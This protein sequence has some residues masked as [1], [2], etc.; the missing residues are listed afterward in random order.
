MDFN[1]HELLN[2]WIDAHRLLK[3]PDGIIIF[4]PSKGRW[5]KCEEYELIFKINN[6]NVDVFFKKVVF[7]YLGRASTTHRKAFEVMVRECGYSVNNIPQL[8]VVSNFLKSISNFCNFYN[9]S[10]FLS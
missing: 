5:C 6:K 7:L 10:I 2:D 8:E 9:S 4:N 3:T 1:T